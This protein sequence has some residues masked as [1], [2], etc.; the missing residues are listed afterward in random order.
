M[1]LQKLC[2]ALCAA[3]ALWPS[4]KASICNPNLH[5]QALNLKLCTVNLN[6]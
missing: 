5:L 6:P 1:G 2:E 4:R 3:V